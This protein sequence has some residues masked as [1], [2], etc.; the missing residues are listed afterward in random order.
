MEAK[1]FKLEDLNCTLEVNIEETIPCAM[2]TI[3]MRMRM[4]HTHTY[5]H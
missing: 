5:M 1:L 4:H 3:Y 2:F